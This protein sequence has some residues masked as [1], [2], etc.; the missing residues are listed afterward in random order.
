MRVKRLT[1]SHFGKVGKLKKTTSTAN[2]VKAILYQEFLGSSATQYGIQNENR[3]IA[4]FQEISGLKVRSCGLF[5]DPKYPFLAASPDGLVGD[6]AI[7]EVKC[8]YNSR[9]STP[10]EATE[11]NITKFL[12]IDSSGDL[13]L[14]NNDN[15]MHQV[16][17]Q[18]NISNTSKCYFIVWTP[19]DLFYQ[20][21]YKDENFW[22]NL[23]PKLVTFYKKALLPE[24]IDPRKVR[25]Q[26]LRKIDI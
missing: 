14:K 20:I 16:Q 19:K 22:N 8:P 21:I 4:Q 23:L 1:A 25:C 6:D 12:M 11:N 26:E 10:K 13:Q 5:V 24:L 2:T 9:M 3:A 18:L 7:V 17:G 15:F